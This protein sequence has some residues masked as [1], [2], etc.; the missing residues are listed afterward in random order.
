MENL[1]CSHCVR[2][3]GQLEATLKTKLHGERGT[4][5]P[6]KLQRDSTGLSQTDEIYAGLSECESI[7]I[8]PYL[9]SSSLRI[10]DVQI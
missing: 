5:F 10:P 7:L 9:G 6:Q 3:Q 2:R 8:L 4:D 1:L